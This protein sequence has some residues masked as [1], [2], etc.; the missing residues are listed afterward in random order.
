VKPGLKNSSTREATVLTFYNTATRRKE[1]F[2]PQKPPKVSL[3]VCGPTV[4]DRAHIGNARSVVVFDLLYRVLK[5]TYPETCYVRNITDVDDKIIEAARERGEAIEMLTQRTLEYFHEDMDA[6]GALRP[7][8]EPHAT[9]Y[10]PE[11]IALIEVLLEKE[12]AYVAEGHVMFHVKHDPNYGKLSGLDLDEQHAGARVAVESYKRDPGDFVLWKPS[13]AED[14]GW[15]SPWG[16]GRPGWHIECSAMNRA[17]MDLP[18]DIH[19]G[20]HDLIFPHHE[21]ENA[22]SCC[23]LGLEKLAQVWMHNGL[24]LVNGQKMSKSLGNFLI[25]NDLL[26]EAPGEAIRLALLSTHYHHP[27][28]WTADTLGQAQDLLNRFYQGLRPYNHL[29]QMAKDAPIDTEIREALSD[30]LNTPLAFSIAAQRLRTLNR[31]SDPQEAAPLA[32]TLFASLQLMGFMQEPPEIFLQ[33]GTGLSEKVIQ[34]K[35]AERLAAK[36]ERNF[37][38]A[39]RIRQELETQGVLLEDTPQGT[40]WRRA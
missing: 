31:A 30:N 33:K 17:F 26:K 36:K 38:A 23:A 35:I 11:M 20:G 21:N 5:H 1:A 6:L 18:L 29:Y 7:T 10:I 40:T 19:G 22:Q 16:R 2:T 32:K 39:D 9:Q 27:L 24:L 12:V 25:V 15:D 37:E 8:H 14:P 28:N 3:Y 13:E 34:G 4:Y